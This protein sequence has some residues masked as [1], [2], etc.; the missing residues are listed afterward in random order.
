MKNK[1][2]AGVDGIA[3]DILVMGAPTIAKALTVMINKSISSGEFPNE[4]KEA[5][6]T[7]VKLQI[8]SHMYT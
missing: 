4:W 8:C 5:L 6:V 2:S 3:Q 1:K 7:P